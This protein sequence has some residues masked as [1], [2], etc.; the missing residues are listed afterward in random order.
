VDREIELYY[1]LKLTREFEHRVSRL[2]AQNKILGGVYSGYGQE[3][4]VVGSVFGL[5]PADYVFPLHRDLGAFLVKG[6]PAQT[7]MAQLYGK[8][9]GLSRGK[10]SFLHGGSLAHGVFGSTSMLAS[11]LPVACGV[12]WR[13]KVKKEQ[14]V[15][16]AFFGEGAGSR[17]DFHEAANFAGIHKLAVVFVCENNHYAYSTPVQKQMAVENVADR[18]VAYGFKG[19][20]CS[21][22]DLHEVIDVMGMAVTR[23]REG[24][25]PTLVECK[26]YRMLGHSAHDRAAY[27]VADEVLRWE[28]RDPI[29]QWEAFLSL[30]GFPLD[31]VKKETEARIARELD[32]AVRFAEESP[33]PKPEEALTDIYATEVPGEPRIRVTPREELAREEP[34]REEPARGGASPV[35][36]ASRALLH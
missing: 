11:T 19:V 33:D 20:Q 14:N 6:V 4:V 23:A 15:C 27:R 32:E 29:R 9:T 30:K 28:A 10:D 1:W 18:A 26:T 24:D 12:A 8:E 3:A 21:G 31:E 36:A 22:N 35:E 5:T 16:V 7:L 13:F 17:G 34:K 2:H 25:G